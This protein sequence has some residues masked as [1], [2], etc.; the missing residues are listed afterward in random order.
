LILPYT[1]PRYRLSGSGIVFEALARGKPFICT[2]GL[3]F[4]DYA[5][6]GMFEAE[7]DE[8]FAQA[9]KSFVANPHPFRVAALQAAQ[10]YLDAQRLGSFLTRVRSVRADR[11]A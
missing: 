6:G 8:G 5:H 9:I 4:S 3:A 10:K 2:A 7:D 11:E 1:S